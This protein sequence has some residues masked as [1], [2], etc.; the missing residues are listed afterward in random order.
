M[1]FC[2]REQQKATYVY[3]RT[4]KGTIISNRSAVRKKV[5]A[6]LWISIAKVAQ[7]ELQRTTALSLKPSRPH[8]Q[9]MVKRMQTG[10]TLPHF[11]VSLTPSAP[12][13]WHSLIPLSLLSRPSLVPNR[14][15]ADPGP[16]EMAKSLRVREALPTQDGSAAE[17]RAGQP[18]IPAQPSPNPDPHD[19]TR[20]GPHPET[21][22]IRTGTSLASRS[23]RSERARAGIAVWRSAITAIYG[24]HSG[25]SIMACPEAAGTRS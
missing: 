4:F 1:T 5:T 7:N 23:E 16:G 25:L 2:P 17:P 24:F 21:V 15:G 14:S 11:G 12:P 10:D 8:Q 18:A 19:V 13:P 9:T 6:L 3:S 20:A 22:R